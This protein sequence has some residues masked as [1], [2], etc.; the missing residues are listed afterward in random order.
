[1]LCN[2]SYQGFSTDHYHTHAL[3]R[4][5]ID[6]TKPAR[7]IHARL[8]ACVSLVVPHW[9]TELTLLVSR[10]STGQPAGHVRATEM[11]WTGTPSLTSGRRLLA[12]LAHC[13]MDMTASAHLHW[14]EA[15]F[16]KLRSALANSQSPR[17]DH[18]SLRHDHNSVSVPTTLPWYAYPLLLSLPPSVSGVSRR[19]PLETWR[20]DYL[21]EVSTTPSADFPPILRSLPWVGCCHIEAGCVHVVMTT[22]HLLDSDWAQDHRHSLL[23]RGHRI[24][25][26]SFFERSAMRSA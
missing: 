18:R 3:V 6:P 16:P 8:P 25:N 14:A 13:N 5:V 12:S 7:N 15:C 20:I 9:S 19:T 2:R 11:K 21:G 1:M 24:W 10:I 17:S 4:G 22:V 26:A 23:D